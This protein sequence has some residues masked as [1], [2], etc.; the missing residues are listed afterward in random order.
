MRN[1]VKFQYL[2]S[3]QV[4]R[5]TILLWLVPLGM[6]SAHTDFGPPELRQGN[7]HLMGRISILFLDTGR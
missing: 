3:V 7:L 4:G 5:R 2:L 6:I 1:V